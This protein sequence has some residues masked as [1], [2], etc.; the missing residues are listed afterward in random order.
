MGQLFK[1]VKILTSSAWLL[2]CVVL[3]VQS[4]NAQKRY[5]SINDAWDATDY[6]ALVQRVE[7]DGLALPTLSSG[8]TK[9]VFERMVHGD[10][11]PLRMGLNKELS[12]TVR[13]QKL[14]PLLQPL[15]QLI[16]FYSN[17]AEKGK[18]YATELARLKVYETKAAGALL[19]I[20]EPYLATLKEDPRYQTHVALLD[21]MKSGARELYSG[22]VK[23]MSETSLYSKSD[24]LAMSRGALNAIASY[25]P[26]FTDQ[27]RQDLT[28]RLRQQISAT[29]DQELKTALTELRDAIKHGRIPT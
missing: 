17:E 10:N 6:R 2:L 15:H 7:N 9:P 28:Q 19:D 18:P 27:D 21:E 12:I 20:G 16:I 3:A 13:Y 22:L 23:S 5:P 11:I 29:T 25:Q 1:I 26:I 8:G 24:I 14:K 4:A